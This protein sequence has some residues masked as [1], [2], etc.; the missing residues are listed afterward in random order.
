M[1]SH[2][3]Q[4][5]NKKRKLNRVLF[6]PLIHRFASHGYVVARVDMRGS[7]DS[8]GVYHGVYLPQEQQDA[9]DIIEWLSAQAWCNGNVG[10]YGKSWSGSNVLQ[11]AYEQP[12]ALKAVIS[13]YSSGKVA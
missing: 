10:M 4:T 7:G 8:E 9:C 11:V 12:P 13:L 1:G 2:E 6:T 3:F 5:Q